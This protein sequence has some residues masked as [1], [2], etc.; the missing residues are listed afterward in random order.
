MDKQTLSN[1]G[2][3]IILVLILSVMLALASPFGLFVSD[4]VKNSVQ[5]LFDVNSSAL[6]TVGIDI[7]NAN[8]TTA[9][10]SETSYYTIEEIEED[11]HL[12]AI[13]K[14]KP[15]YV[16]AKFN[17]DYSEVIITKNGDDSDGMM[18][19][20]AVWSGNGTSPMTTHGNTLETVIIK[21]GVASIGHGGGG[22]S[23]FNRCKKLT[24]I[25][26][27]DSLV[28]MGDNAF[29]N[30]TALTVAP[31]IP[32]SVTSMNG[33]F[34]GCTS[35][36]TAPKIPSGVI[37]MTNTFCG[38]KNLKTYTGSEDKDGDFS[39]YIIPNNVTRMH[40]T[41]QECRSLTISPAI[42]NNVTVMYRTFTDCESLTVA[43]KIPDDVTDMVYTFQ[44]CK[45]L[46]TAPIIPNKVTDLT[47]AFSGC[48]K[49]TIAPDIPNSVTN[50]GF[51]FSDCKSLKSVPII[52]ENV[53]SVHA[54]FQNCTALTGLIEINASIPTSTQYSYPYSD[55][56]DGVD[57]N[58]QNLTLKGTSTMLDYIGTTGINYCTACNGKC[59][60]N[61]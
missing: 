22:T 30:C 37:D 58:S 60:N 31:V 20:F 15:E 32:N 25:T 4:A 28:Y 36:T 5:G 52:S 61:H 53:T 47:W 9:N 55:C 59:L 13:G 54:A 2:W 21:E 57:F 17:D 43:P 50:I 10:S 46:T 23:T 56:F 8:L 18:C 34:M 14:T 12:Y 48:S 26:L 38:C 1:Y 49:L 33:T 39:N 35:L 40:S 42:P 6:S 3:I 44:N 24:S 11:E 27:P 45:S 7:P 51:A 41:F 29:S 19:D 16:V